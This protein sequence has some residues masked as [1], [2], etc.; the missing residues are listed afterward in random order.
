MSPLL[1]AQG[2]PLPP[3]RPVPDVLDQ[4]CDNRDRVPNA[5]NEV[6][7]RYDALLAELEPASPVMLDLLSGKGQLDARTQD[8]QRLIRL[9][10][11]AAQMSLLLRR[12]AFRQS[13]RE[14][15]RLEENG[16]ERAPA[17]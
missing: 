7:N 14:A 6:M 9:A 12:H 13:A 16:G 11:D 17:G 15:E 2:N 3:T 8:G 10:I 5:W 1:D 4:L